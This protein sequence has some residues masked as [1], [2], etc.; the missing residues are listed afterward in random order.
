VLRDSATK[1]GTLITLKD[2][3]F[4]GSSH[5][6]L[7]RSIPVLEDLLKAMKENPAIEIEIRGYV[8]C[9]PSDLDGYDMNSHTENLS[10]NRARIVY[11]YLQKHGIE[12]SRLSYKGFGGSNKLY[13]AE[14][15]DFEQEANRRVEIKIVK[16]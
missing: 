7:P 15:T 1:K 12:A 5:M 14:A 11:E 13:P 2:L 16:K 4:Y 3:N 10:V 9:T 6:L 8:C